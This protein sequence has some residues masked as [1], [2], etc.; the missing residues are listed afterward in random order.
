[1]YEAYTCSTGNAGSACGSTLG[2][3]L[4]MLDTAGLNAA[5]L[6]AAGLNG[7]RDCRY[8]EYVGAWD[9]AACSYANFHS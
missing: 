5:G 7:C 2:C 9:N 3:R 6:N 4:R 1:M 8:V